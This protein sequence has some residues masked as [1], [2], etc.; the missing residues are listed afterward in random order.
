MF[1][2]V[3]STLQLLVQWGAKKSAV[4]QSEANFPRFTFIYQ[5]HQSCLICSH[6]MHGQ[7]VSC[8]NQSMIVIM[9]TYDIHVKKDIFIYMSVKTSVGTCV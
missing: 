7:E 1:E 8:M 6:P 2:T 3:V 5:I 4:Q 9:M